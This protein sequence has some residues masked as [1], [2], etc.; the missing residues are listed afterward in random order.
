MKEPEV[1]QDAY[2]PSELYLTQ[3]HESP[4]GDL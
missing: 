1:G 2:V 4:R 3:S